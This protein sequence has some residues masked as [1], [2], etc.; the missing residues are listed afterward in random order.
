LVYHGNMSATE[1]QVILNY[2][3]QMNPFLTTQ[4]LQTAVFLALNADSYT[5]SN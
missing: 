3:S 5:V 1:Q 4:Q 2:C